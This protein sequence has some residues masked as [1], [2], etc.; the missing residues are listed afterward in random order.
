[1]GIPRFFLF[2]AK[3]YPEL[4]KELLTLPPDTFI[5]GLYI[6]LNSVIH[7]VAQRLF[8][9]GLNR[10]LTDQDRE[11]QEWFR[12][13]PVKQRRSI[14]FNTIGS[15]LAFAFTE[16]KPTRVFMIAIDGV[17]PTSKMVQQRLRRFKPGGSPLDF[18]DPV[19]ISPGT[20]F[21]DELD[22]YLKTEWPQ[23]FKSVFPVGLNIIYSGHREPGE[24]EHK[25]FQQMNARLGATRYKT[26]YGSKNRRSKP[27]QVVVG[28]DSDL[29]IL[30]LSK[31]NNI[32]FMREKVPDFREKNKMDALEE[33]VNTHII[34]PCEFNQPGRETAKLDFIN[35]RWINV[36]KKGF[37][38][39]DITSMRENI[40]DEFIAP[41]DV[42]DF[43]FISFFVG[44]DFLPALPE[45]D[46]VVAMSPMFFADE[47]I[48]LRFRDSFR[49]KREPA[50]DPSQRRLIK[51]E[52]FQEVQRKFNPK[53][54]WDNFR[55][56]EE[57]WYRKDG[58]INFKFAKGLWNNQLKREEMFP[59]QSIPF[60]DEKKRFLMF[61]TSKGRWITPREDIGVLNRALLIYQTYMKFN[62]RYERGES[63]SFIVENKEHINYI[64]LYLYL[65]EIVQYLQVF[66]DA[67]L[68]QH[69]EL[70]KRGRE[71]SDLI[72]LSVGVEEIGKRKR[73]AF[74]APAFS[75]IHKAKSFGIY[76]SE[77]A[78]PKLPKQSVSEMCRKWLEGAQWTLRYYS[79]GLNKVNTRWF[80]P[81]KAS[82]SVIDLMQYLEDRII[83]TVPGFPGARLV[84]ETS[85]TVEVERI[86]IEGAVIY[87]YIDQ[88]GKKITLMKTIENVRK[89]IDLNSI[90][91][92][93][94]KPTPDELESALA[95]NKIP[96]VETRRMMT[97]IKVHREFPQAHQ[98]FDIVTSPN[99]YATVLESFFSILPISVLNKILPDKV[100]SSV[101]LLLSDAFPLNFQM[102]TEGK[103]Y[104]SQAT[105]KIPF[106]SPSR[107]ERALGNIPDEFN[108]LITRFNRTDKRLQILH[109]GA[110]I[111]IKPLRKEFVR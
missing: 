71:P 102:I 44:N 33:A 41:N 21:M 38:Y 65:K 25:I 72:E 35:G 97:R 67:Q 9:Y 63:N 68:T 23:K 37:S 1:M 26:S 88:E 103:F 57:T 90:E 40:L 34:T 61:K 43:A 84:S 105:P 47:D 27:Y 8:K 111:K 87:N 58:S 96:L 83:T 55:K 77:Y 36:F 82:P 64:N 70:V 16:I 108:D 94:H 51:K 49:L 93:N 86:N 42:M 107:V 39:V 10:E 7:G 6:D 29:I 69:Q 99:P 53:L 80:Y 110:T 104:E 28:A 14:F 78:D 45:F 24:G 106:P 22:E 56:K 46:A 30:S 74:V 81:F 52:E 85:R 17:A 95:R 92:F 20:D 91:F 48:E 76:D 73:P 98:I 109:T 75:N 5:E 89:Y 12:R 50:R 31:A 13:M 101:T 62:R 18:F 19:I 66:M 32:I 79:S 15:Y 11:I 2:L 4:I 3:T 100:V 60:T 59:V 54:F